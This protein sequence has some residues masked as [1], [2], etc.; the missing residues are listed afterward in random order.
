MSDARRDFETEYRTGEPP[1]DIG[2]PQPEVVRL[3]EEGAFRGHVLDV[4]CGTG[5]NA[6]FLAGRGLRVTG[7]DAAPT[8]LARAREKAKARG[9]E[10]PFVACDAL[11]LRAL[12]ERFDTV[13]DCGL[14]HV[15]DEE[16]A[17]RYAQSLADAVGS[18]G[19]LQLLCF[20]DEEPPGPGPRRV[21][22]WDVRSAF[23]GLFVLSRI[24]AGRFQTRWPEVEPRAWVVTLTRL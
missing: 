12:K 2:A 19:Q 11:D 1:W 18:G 20:S 13:L 23:R 4:G 6:L 21:T 15:F 22:E 16:A 9:V 17:K 8:A 10:V 24:R 5:E 3:A 7:A 14:F